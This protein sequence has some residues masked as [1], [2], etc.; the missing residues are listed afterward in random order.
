MTQIRRRRG[1]R[2]GEEPFEPA[3]AA[4]PRACERKERFFSRELKA[5]PTSPP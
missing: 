1:R 2:A 4:R 5:E 3:M